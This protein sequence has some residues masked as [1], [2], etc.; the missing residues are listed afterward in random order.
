MIIKPI[1]TCLRAGLSNELE[2]K[3]QLLPSTFSNYTDLQN[4]CLPSQSTLLEMSTTPFG[5][6]LKKFIP[7]INDIL[8]Y[9]Q[10]PVYRM[11]ELDMDLLP[12]GVGDSIIENSKIKVLL[13]LI[14]LIPVLYLGSCLSLDLY[15]LFNELIID[16]SLLEEI[17]QAIGPQKYQTFIDIL[18]NIED[19][20]Q[21]IRIAI[22]IL[23]EFIHVLNNKDLDVKGLNKIIVIL[24]ENL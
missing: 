1:I 8:D 20:P 22:V 16:I 3:E 23:T 9:Q 24:L 15:Q 4:G 7:H 6:Y 5:L 18:Y 12:M 13:Y 21:S 11:L 2:K 19:N 17:N 10:L 14:I